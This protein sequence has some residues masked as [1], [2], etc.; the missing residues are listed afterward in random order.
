MATVPAT[1]FKAQC[2]ELMDRVAEGRRSYVIT[3][4]GKPVA[5]LVPV[6]APRGTIFGC[7]ADRTEFVGDIGKSPRT[8]EQ[9]DQLAAERRAR[10]QAWEREWQTHG[11]IT[12]KKTVGQPPHL[13]RARSGRRRRAGLSSEGKGSERSRRASGGRR[14]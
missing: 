4:R 9:W 3:K 11:T 14:S 7:M 8:D 10:R 2:L 1:K 6:D 12:G 5:K 13:E